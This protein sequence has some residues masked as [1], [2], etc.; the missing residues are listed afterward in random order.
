M[1]ALRSV[2]L[3][4]LFLTVLVSLPSPCIVRA[5]DGDPP[6]DGSGNDD[7]SNSDSIITHIFKLIFPIETMQAAT[8]I[9][10][11]NILQ[12]NAEGIRELF[13]G[14]VADL[15]LQNPGIKEPSGSL[16]WRGVD[17]FAP[18]WNFTVKIAVALWPATLAV[19]AALAAQ[20]SAISTD[21]GVA[22]LKGALGQ[23]LGGVLACAFSLEIIDLVNR[24]SNAIIEGII[25]LPIRGAIGLNVE[26]I[27]DAL[28]GAA[29]R[30]FGM[31]VSP[32]AAIVAV[33]VELVLGLA[34]VISII[35]QYFGRVALLYIIVALAP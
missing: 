29:L 6:D 19:M 22:G 12:R 20:E 25:T 2:L 35:G 13:S 7:D 24:L 34:L 4:G 30:V 32:A 31:G 18:T 9:L 1:K 23:W 28:L 11:V 33:L 21:W 3:V 10:L 14:I 16:V 27:V 8:E 15:T 26:A 5:Q 17:V